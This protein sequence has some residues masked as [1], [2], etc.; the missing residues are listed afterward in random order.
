MDGLIEKATALLNTFYGPGFIIE[1]AEATGPAKA[2]FTGRILTDYPDREQRFDRMDITVE[3]HTNDDGQWIIRRLK[4]I[5][6]PP[7]REAKP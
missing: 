4:F 1:S 3:L 6:S 7:N 5:Q 2:H